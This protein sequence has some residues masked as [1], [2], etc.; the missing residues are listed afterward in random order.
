MQTAKPF[1]HSLRR[2]ALPSGTAFALAVLLTAVAPGA[3]AAGRAA[4]AMPLTLEQALGLA[5]T[6]NLTVRLSQETAQQAA[7]AAGQAAVATLPSIALRGSQQRSDTVSIVNGE[8]VPSTPGNRFDGKLTGSVT[9]LNQQQRSNWRAAQAGVRV[10]ELDVQTAVQTSLNTVAQAYF[11]HLRNLRRIDVLNANVERAQVLLT[12]ARNQAAA[13]VATQIDVTRAEALLAQAEQTRMQQQTLV[14]GSEIALLR[15]LDLP[16]DRSLQ[17]VDF[18]VRRTLP[19]AAASDLAARAR[20]PEFLRVERA[21]EQSQ[22][23]VRAA[24]AGRLPTVGLT[25][26]YG[27]V[28]ATFGDRDNETAWLAAA[29]LSVPLFDGWKTRS[30]LQLALSKQRAQE[31]RKRQVEQLIATELRLAHQDASSRLAQISV[32]EKSLRLADEELRLARSR[33]EQGVADNRE[34]VEAQN[35]IALA[36]DGLVEAEYQYNLARLELARV[37]GDIRALLGEKAG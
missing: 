22:L 21:I 36:A 10:A 23:E 14:F 2:S 30:D 33:Y 1:P 34:V 28:A 13:G 5:E 31:L 20:R 19:A 27:T 18:A 8:P 25:G 11:T 7:A 37:E 15:L 12:L 16:A 3:N 4:E 24:R 26:E 29:T 6:A 17:L 32:A 9:L 35:R